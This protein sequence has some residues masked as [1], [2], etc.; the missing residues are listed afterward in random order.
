MDFLCFVLPETKELE[1]RWKEEVPLSQRKLPT[2]VLSGSGSR[3]FL[4]PAILR[5]TPVS[6]IQLK[7]R[8]RE[9]GKCGDAGGVMDPVRKKRHSLPPFSAQNAEKDG[10]R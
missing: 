9:E 2:P 4:S 5:S 8:G 7:H 3:V 10:S 1:P 6:T